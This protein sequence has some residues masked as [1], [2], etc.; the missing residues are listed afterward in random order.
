MW[1]SW[2]CTTSEGAGTAEVVGFAMATEPIVSAGIGGALAAAVDG[3]VMS[4]FE[5]QAGSAPEGDL[6][7]RE[8]F[9][10]V[11]TFS[12]ISSCSGYHNARYARGG[13]R[14]GLRWQCGRSRLFCG[15]GVHSWIS[16]VWLVWP[17]L[18]QG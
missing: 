14:L 7:R 4:L 9:A 6:V 17:L 15:R 8:A 3:Q 12:Q 18:L 2:P 16:D 10:A 5:A 13:L 1:E 11:R